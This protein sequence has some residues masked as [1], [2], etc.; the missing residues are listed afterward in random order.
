[1]D[2]ATITVGE[3]EVTLY[4][5]LAALGALAAWGGCILLSPSHRIR[6]GKMVL[7]GP[8]AA[9]L[10]LLLGRL[11]YC[12][13]MSDDLFYDEMGHSLGLSPFFDLSQGSV[14]VIGVIAGCLLAAP[15]TGALTEEKAGRLLDAAALPGLLFFAFARLIEPLSGHGYGIDVETEAL[16]FFPLMLENGGLA[17]CYIEAAL[18]LLIA[19]ALLPVRSRCCR[20]G[21]LFLTAL[22]LLSVSQILPESFR[23]DE[24][25]FIFIFARVNQLGH[26]LFLALALI[27][28][29]IRGKGQ[30]RFVRSGAIDLLLLLL[31][32]G[33]CIAAEFSLEGK[34]G[35]H[36]PDLI[37]YGIMGLALCGMAF[38]TLRRVWKGDTL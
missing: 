11:I 1:M 9:F 33:V 5:L 32:A 17:V 7:Y 15:L 21:T 35:F 3:G 24:Y 12:A 29:L 10:G 4:G 27:L 34:L 14:C 6:R 30:P 2:V 25:L 38:V 16:Q 37:I 26:A 20:E 13:L 22:T 8:L 19:A 31:G 28:A 36:W 18:A 23:Q